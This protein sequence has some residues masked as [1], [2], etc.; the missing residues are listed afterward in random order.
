MPS[1]GSAAVY[2]RCPV[3]S[4]TTMWR[5]FSGFD[6]VRR[7]EVEDPKGIVRR[8]YDAISVRYDAWSDGDTK[9]RGWLSELGELMPE[10]ASVLDLGC[11]SGL[12]VA[13]DLTTAGFHVTGVD[14]SAVQIQRAQEL[15]PDAQFL[16]AD[17]S[18]VEFES[19]SFDAVVSFFALI[20]VPLDD[21]RA[22]LSRVASWLRPGGLFVATT[23]YWAWTG[24]EENWL[25]GGAPMWW[26]HA[27]A[28]TYR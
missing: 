4:Q 18:C 22:L 19:E 13:R 17:I 9:Y 8:G 5:G 10:G 11:G 21:Q 16:L 1:G 27:D 14:I 12:P 2:P 25:D 24:Y 26:S 7:M 23:G 3:L 15:V 28:A 6:S 20:H